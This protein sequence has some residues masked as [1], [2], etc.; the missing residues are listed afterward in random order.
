MAWV[1]VLLIKKGIWRFLAANVESLVE[2]V[3]GNID[4]KNLEYFHEF[5]RGYTDIFTN[6][7]Y[8]T[9]DYTY[10]NLLGMIQN[11]DIVVV[12]ADKG[13]SLVIMKK[14]D[15]VTKLDALIDD[16]IIK[17]A[18]VETSGN[19][20]KELRRFQG[21]LY[22]S[23]HNYERYKDMQPDSNQPARLYGTA[24]THTFGTL[25]DIVVAKLKFR[26]IID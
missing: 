11:K 8:A 2:S 12:K 19:T 3:K 1:I 25:E 15:D 23:F 20:L 6:N 21:F 22:R 7:I 4:H 24:K 14:S 26:P 17:S 13:S 10:H 9:K 5:L 16:G 18:Y